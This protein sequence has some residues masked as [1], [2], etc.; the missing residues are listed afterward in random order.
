MKVI[1]TL[2]ALALSA[3]AATGLDQMK[4]L[5]GHWTMERGAIAM[6]EIWSP[7]SGDAMM[8]MFRVVSGGKTVMYELNAITVS[9]ETLTIQLRHFDGKMKVKGGEEDGPVTLP[10]AS[11]GATEATFE[12][13]E[14]GVS[15]R[16][17][18][19]RTGDTLDIVLDK[20]GKKTPFRFQ[21]KK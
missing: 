3:S 15:V 14:D 18:Y 5:T 20:G 2:L 11:S 21:L 12:G 1:W 19:K 7:A 6:D 8:G 13:T 17:V 9:G 4:W 10:L 16:L